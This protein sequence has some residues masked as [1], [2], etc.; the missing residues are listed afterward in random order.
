[1]QIYDIETANDGRELTVHGSEDFPCAF[2]DEKFSEFVAGEVPWHWH[3]EFE[4][5]LVIE[6]CTKIECIGTSDVIYPGEMVLV[7]A[8]AL[9]K[10]TNYGTQDC[11]ILNILFSPLM[12]GGSLFSRIYKKFVYPVINNPAFL[13]YK[14]S[15][16]NGWHDQV[17]AD[18]SIAFQAWQEQLSSYELIMNASLL[19]CWQL[20]CVNEPQLRSALSV[21]SI[22]AQR[23][24]RL[25]QYIHSHYAT[26]LSV[27]SISQSANISES[28]CYRL[29]KSTLQC[30]PN[31]Y[32]LNYRL[33]KSTTLLIETNQS[34][35]EIA[36]LNGFNCA[37]YFAK[38]FKLAYAKTP[39][40]FRKEERLQADISDEGSS[41]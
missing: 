4:I 19:K 36:H 2:Y 32:L 6:G 17:I 40:Q 7:N 34:V 12:L 1:M 33:R 8:K 21:Q 38:K 18:L 24:Q 26:S 3:D 16:D 14:F 10:Y 13:F 41:E 5:V 15:P 27:L 22:S 23:I 9:H 37:A 29:F 11:R 31:N 39:K 30:T 35:T 20:L 28:E 25:L